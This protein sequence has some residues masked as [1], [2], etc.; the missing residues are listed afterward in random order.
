MRPSMRTIS[1]DGRV[2]CFPICDVKEIANALPPPGV[3]KSGQSLVHATAIAAPSTM[4][5]DAIAIAAEM[6]FRRA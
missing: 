1:G 3:Q 2:G 5:L 4:T 6:P